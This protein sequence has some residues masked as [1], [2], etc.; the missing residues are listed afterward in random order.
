MCTCCAAGRNSKADQLD[1][2]TGTVHGVRFKCQHFYPSNQ[3]QSVHLCVC[4]QVCLSFRICV[5]KCACLSLSL[6]V[7]LSSCVYHNLHVC[8]C[9]SS[10]VCVT[11]PEPWLNG[12][13]GRMCDTMAWLNESGVWHVMVLLFISQFLGRGTAVCRFIELK[14]LN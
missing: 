10:F 5:S 9:E 6:L 8:L 4:L 1:T 11:V 3:S 12:I 7:W 2:G 13:R 14:W